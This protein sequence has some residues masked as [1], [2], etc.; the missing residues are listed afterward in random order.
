MGNQDEY[1]WLENVSSEKCLS[2]VR[3]QNQQ[4]IDVFEREPDFVKS[5]EDLQNI[6]ESKEKIPFVHFIDDGFVYN[7]WTDDK[8]VQGV[9]RRTTIEDY[10]NANPRWE[11]IIDLDVLSETDGQK[12]VSRGMEI[13][14]S[15]KRALLY[16]SPG[17]SDANVVREFDLQTKIF[18]KDGFDLPISKGGACWANE[19]EIYLYRDFGPKSITDSGYARTIR[20]WKRGEPQKSAEIIFE[21]TVEDVG[22]SIDAFHEGSGASFIVQRRIDFYSGEI[23]KYDGKTF[24]TVGLPPK[25]ELMGNNLDALYVGLREDWK[26]FLSG[27]VIVHYYENE[28]FELVYRPE[29]NSAVFAGHLLKDGILLIVD[30]DVRGHLLFLTKERGSWKKEQVDLPINGS[31]GSLIAT[32]AGNDFFITFDSFNTPVSYFYGKKNKIEAIVKQQPGFFDYKNIDVHQHFTKSL[33]GTMVPYFIVHQK[34]LQYD[35][36]NPTILYG[37]GGFEI[38]LK[39]HFNNVLGKAWLEKGGVYVLAN[40]RGGGE[41]GPLWHQSALKEKRHR[42]YEDFFAIAENLFHRRI[43]SPEHLGAQGGSNGGLLMGVCFTQRPDLFAAINCGV[44]LLD[45]RRYH[46]LL[47]GHSWIAEYGNPDD[48]EDGKY[49]RNL[50]PY[51]QINKEQK[52]YPV[53]FLNTS[54]KDDRVHPA[55]A[56]KFAAKLQEY[57]HKYFYHENINGGHAGFSNLKELAF[58]EALDYAFFWKH[59]K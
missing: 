35:G 12:W 3:E 31:L 51:H 53:I 57:G 4:M 36:K 7:T 29:P 16:L 49:I 1:L 24:K 52:N 22:V 18:V 6:L 10:K 58:I 39:P 46:K 43:T 13:S 19:N 42:A 11:V 38:S 45:M 32:P 26:G 56:R 55:H 20:K 23:L 30:V 8:N 54:T 48:E 21:T 59:L 47:A 9:V 44:P 17:G 40:I 2:W 34:G 28:S 14:P 37:Y 15:K 5:V 27:D 33:D 25:F 50:S 41:Y